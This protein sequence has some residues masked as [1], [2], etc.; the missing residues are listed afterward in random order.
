MSPSH[1]NPVGRFIA[2]HPQ[3]SEVIAVLV[4]LLLV[5]VLMGCGSAPRGD[6]TGP[7]PIPAATSAPPSAFTTALAFGYPAEHRARLTRAAVGQCFALR[8]DPS[9]T[10]SEAALIHASALAVTMATG[11]DVT[12]SA[13]CPSSIHIEKDGEHRLADGTPITGYAGL[14]YIDAVDGWVLGGRVILNPDYV[15][16]KVVMHEL[17][18]VV[19]FMHPGLPGSV[20][21]DLPLDAQRP[22]RVDVDAWDWMRAQPHGLAGPWVSSSSVGRRFIQCGGAQ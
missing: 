8:L 13:A 12:F 2:R 19:G 6:V 22:A 11:E 20:M 15:R 7:A 10:S 3:A 21:S 1:R 5:V 14:A 9:F 17:L 16:S 18:H 4:A